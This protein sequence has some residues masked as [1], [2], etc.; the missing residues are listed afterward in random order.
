MLM[1]MK[2]RRMIWSTDTSSLI[3]SINTQ[4]R[5]R[6]WWR[7]E[8]RRSSVLA[9]FRQIVHGGNNGERNSYLAL[10]VFSRQ[11]WQLVLELPLEFLLE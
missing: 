3:R 4:Y 1:S 11:C 8:M 10:Y 7:R 9:L 2:R 6:F 5:K